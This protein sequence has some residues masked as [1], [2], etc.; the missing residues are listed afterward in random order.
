[1]SAIH[2]DPRVIADALHIE[3][4]DLIRM[5]NDWAAEEMPSVKYS[6][7]YAPTDLDTFD[8]CVARARQYLVEAHA[9]QHAWDVDTFPKGGERVQIAAEGPHLRRE[10]TIIATD[11]ENR[12]VTVEMPA[13]DDDPEAATE[14][15][16]LG[17][18]DVFTD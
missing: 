6:D 11:F 18:V 7:K 10:G 13:T 3:L 5:L 8:E 4:D 2:V 16:D 17:L 15:F 12:Q 9:A 14:T 1:M